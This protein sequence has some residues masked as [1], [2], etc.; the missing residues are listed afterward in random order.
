MAD[1][2]SGPH[3]GTGQPEV[4]PTAS[5]SIR[6][7]PCRKCMPNCATPYKTPRPLKFH[8]PPLDIAHAFD[9]QQESFSPIWKVDGSFLV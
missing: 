5:T 3:G 9:Q 1:I 2:P 6:R 8:D 7:I 4:G